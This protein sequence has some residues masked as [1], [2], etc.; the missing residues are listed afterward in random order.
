M[1][2]TRA[3][4]PLPEPAAAAPRTAPQLPD[5]PTCRCERRC[6][7]AKPGR[8]A[9]AGR[10]RAVRPADPKGPAQ[11]AS[12]TPD[13]PSPSPRHRAWHSPGPAAVTT[14]PL[15]L[16]RQPEHAHCPNV[17]ARFGA[18]TVRTVSCWPAAAMT[19][20][21]RCGTYRYSRIRMP[22]CAPTSALPPGNSGISTPQARRFPR[23]AP[24]RVPLGIA[25]VTEL[26][27][28]TW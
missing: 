12:V 2:S 21:C 27:F 19:A 14:D 9:H 5:H 15:I 10:S 8:P 22:R 13:R 25:A 17:S 20:W 24:D 28:L 3:E 7:G 18:G 16:R 23:S 11:S 4:R 1:A 6:L 26:Q